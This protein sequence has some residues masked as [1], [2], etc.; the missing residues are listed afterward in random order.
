MPSVSDHVSP[1]DAQSLLHLH[2]TSPR[3]RTAESPMGL[4]EAVASSV[5]S[6]L[7]NDPRIVAMAKDFESRPFSISTLKSFL[8]LLRDV[9][10]IGCVF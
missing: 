3:L 8:V 7:S 6:L 5:D 2:T 1:L 9:I 4:G 10:P